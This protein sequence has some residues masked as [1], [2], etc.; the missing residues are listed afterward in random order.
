[1]YPVYFSLGVNRNAGGSVGEV[2]K[3]IKLG[4]GQRTK[5]LGG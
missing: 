5:A 2:F 3:R 1:M 4:R